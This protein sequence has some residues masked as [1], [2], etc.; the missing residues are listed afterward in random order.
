MT[1][2]QI[3]LYAP[4]ILVAL[5]GVRMLFQLSSVVNKIDTI[6]KRMG[7]M[8]KLHTTVATLQA[9]FEER[10]KSTNRRLKVLE[11]DHSGHSDIPA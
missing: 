7:K 8:E 5:T 2:E 10:S 1:P 11:S 9:Q 3:A 4:V 6:D